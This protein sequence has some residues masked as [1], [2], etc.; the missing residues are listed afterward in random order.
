[1]LGYDTCLKF[2]PG[3]IPTHAPFQAFYQATALL[4]GS[5]CDLESL[6]VLQ[7][8]QKSLPAGICTEGYDHA[9]ADQAQATGEVQQDGAECSKDKGETH[10]AKVVDLQ[11]QMAALSQQV[12]RLAT[13]Q[14]E[15]LSKQVRELEQQVRL[16]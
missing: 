10:E 4:I 7:Q 13:Q 15:A 5:K 2:P 8:E 3:P 12:A 11:S 1:M 16:Q 14:H 9:A 6:C